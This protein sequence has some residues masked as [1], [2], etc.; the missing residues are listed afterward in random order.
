MVIRDWAKT[1][2]KASF[3]GANFWVEDE[4]FTGGKRV[5]LHEY[6]GGRFTYLEEMGL[7]TSA[8][9]VTAYLIGDTSDAQAGRLSDAA[10]A[11]GP[12]RLVLPADGGRLAYVIDFRRSRSR[13]KAGYFAF[14]FTAIPITNEAGAVMG[15][16]NMTTAVLAGMSGAA[17]AFGGFF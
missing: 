17:L 16:A 9:E 12:G 11:A 10:Q 3:R 13:D 15:V 2:R 6:A 8:Y 1:L 7:A 5:A 14:D 4:S